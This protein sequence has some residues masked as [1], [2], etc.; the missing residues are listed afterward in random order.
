MEQAF[1]YIFDRLE[2]QGDYSFL[3]EGLL[4]E[5]LQRLVSLDEAF[6]KET[7]VEDGTAAYDDDAAAQAISKGLSEAYPEYRMYMLRLT[8]DYL[9]YNEEYLDSIGAIEWD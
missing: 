6:M 5:M 8:E 2:K 4:H 3:P 7:G 9:D 1:S